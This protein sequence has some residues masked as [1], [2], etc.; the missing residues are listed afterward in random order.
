[1]EFS[2]NFSLLRYSEPYLKIP[3]II[4]GDLLQKL[5]QYCAF[6]TYEGLDNII[7]D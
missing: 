4:P 2:A 7:S 1:M 5:C 6:H 3:S